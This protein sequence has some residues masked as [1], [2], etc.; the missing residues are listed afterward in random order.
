MQSRRD[1]L[2]TGAGLA[3]AGGIASLAGCSNVPVVGSYFEGEPD[4]TEWAYDPDELGSSSISADLTDISSVLEEDEVKKGE[5]RDDVTSNYSGTLKADNVDYSLNVGHAQILTGSFDGA[6]IVEEMEFSSEDSYEGFDVYVDEEDED[7]EGNAS[8]LIG[9]DGDYLIKSE[10]AQ[11]VDFGPREELEL[12]IDTYNDDADRFADTNDD[13][14]TIRDEV[15]LGAAVFVQGQTESS[16]EEA[17]DDIVV[18]TGATL[19]IDGEEMNVEYLL[20]YKSED[21]I[22]I[23]EIEQNFEDNMQEE[24]ELND[25]S[26]DGRLVTVDYT[27]PTEKF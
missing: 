10:P 12:L 2:R 20:L 23:D 8:A 13:F 9:T 16:A 4:I 14:A 24:S 25:V 3:A 6:D 27:M 22:D 21:G 17:S 19:T 1:V 15:E 26:Q 7:E 5:I 18:A 11:Y